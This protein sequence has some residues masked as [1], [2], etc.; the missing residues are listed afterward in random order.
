MLYLGLYVNLINFHSYFN[1]VR[2]QSSH[3]MSIRCT[4]KCI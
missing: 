2:K 3:E 1:A 4:I